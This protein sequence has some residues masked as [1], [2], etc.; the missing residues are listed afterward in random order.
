MAVKS[1]KA[2]IQIFNTVGSPVQQFEYDMEE[3]IN[4]IPLSAEELPAGIYLVRYLQD[5]IT[6]T[7]Q[8]VK[9]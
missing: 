9:Q 5:D 3:G 7:L 1:G 8:V 2:Q 6:Y 4:F